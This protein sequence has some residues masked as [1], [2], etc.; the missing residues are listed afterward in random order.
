MLEKSRKLY[1][2]MQQK[3]AAEEALKALNIEIGVAN[4]E[5][6]ALMTEAQQQS[7]TDAVSGIKWSVERILNVK[8]TDYAKLNSEDFA[9]AFKDIGCDAFKYV[10]HH[11]TLKKI[12][13]E[14][15][16]I[17]DEFG[18]I[19]LPETIQPFIEVTAF[20]QAKCKAGK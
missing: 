19:N 7:F 8:E 1:D 11:A 10:I 16:M 6:V 14:T 13:K 18:N 5:L 20:M 17:E 3:E 9:Q 15:I 4:N 12:V 2:L